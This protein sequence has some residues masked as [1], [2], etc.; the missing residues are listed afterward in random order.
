MKRA[1]RFLSLFL[2]F[3]MTFSLVSTTSFADETLSESVE[4]AVEDSGST[5]DL[6]DESA[7]AEDTDISAEIAADDT[8]EEETEIETETAEDEVTNSL[9]LAGTSSSTIG[10]KP[11]DGTT[12]DQPFAS[13]TGGSSNFRIPA[14]V[15]LNDGTIVA[16]ADARWNNTFDGYGLDTIVARSTDNGQTWNYTF[17]NYLGDNGNVYNTSSTAF[18]DPSLATDGSTVYMLVDLYPG[19]TYIGN[20]SAGTGY[21]SNGHLLLSNNNRSSFDYYVGDYADGYANIYSSD[22]TAVSGYTVDEYFNLY[23]NGTLTSNVFYDD[24]D[25]KV[26]KTSYLYLTK[27]TDGG[28]T[29]S[30]PSMLNSQV[31][32]SSDYFYG[33]GP[34]HGIVTSTGRIIYSCYT[35]AGAD[36]NTSV[37]YSDDGGATWNRSAGMAEQTSEG[38][39]T[40]ADGN[41]YLF[42]RHGGYY[43]SSDNGSTWSFVQSVSGISYTISCELSVLT[44][45]QKIDGKTAI[46]LSAPTSN[47]TNGKIFVGL[48][49]DDGSISWKYTYTVNN[50][51]FQYSCLSETSD[52]KVALLY[53]NGAASIVFDAYDISTVAEGASIGS[54]DNTP[55]TLT[56]SNVTVA[57]TEHVDS[58]TVAQTTVSSI[59]NAYVAFEVTPGEGYDATSATVTVLLSDALNALDASQLTG[60]YIENGTVNK[61]SGTKNSNGTYTF[62][63]PH[64]STVGVMAVNTSSSVDVYSSEESVTL[65]VGQTK[66]LTDSTGNYE[67]SYTGN[68]LD[69]GIA[70]ASVKGSTTEETTEYTVTKSSSISTGSSYIIGNGTYYLT[71]NGS[72]L[73]VTT[74]PENATKWNFTSSGYSGYR[75]YS[76]S[77]YLYRSNNSV[78]ASNYNATTWYYDSSYGFYCYGNYYSY[79]LI[80][81]SNGA[82]YSTSRSTAVAPYTLSSTTTPGEDITN[83]TFTGVSEGTTAVTVGSVKYNITVIAAP[84]EFTGSVSVAGG[85]STTVALTDLN[86]S[87]SLGAGQYVEWSAADSTIADIYQTSDTGASIIGHKKGS[88]TVTATVYNEDDSAAATYTWTVTV[89]S[90]SSSTGDNT[91]TLSANVTVTNGRLYYSI[92][93]TTVK[94]A[95]LVSETTDSYGNTVRTYTISETAYRGSNNAIICY[96]VAPDDGYALTSIAD[97]GTTKGQYY[98]IDTEEISMTYPSSH[99]G[100]KLEDSMTDAEVKAMLSQAV[101]YGC[102]A[103]YWNSRSTSDSFTYSNYCNKLPTVSKEITSVTHNN[104][105][106]DYVEGSTVITVGDTITYTVKLTTYYENVDITYSNAVL[107]DTMSSGSGNAASWTN[108]NVTS[109]LGNGT[110]QT[111]ASKT[112]EYEVTYVVD[113][114]DVDSNIINTIDLNYDYY[115]NYEEGSYNGSDSAEAKVTI[116]SFAPEDIVIDY[117][118][119]V[120]IDY[121]ENHGTYDLA[122]GTANYGD[123]DVKDNVI[124]YTP[125]TVLTEAD[126]VT[127]KNVKDVEYTFTVYPAT[128]VYYEEGFAVESASKGSGKQTTVYAEKETSSNYGYDDAYS[129][130]TTDSNGT[131]AVLSK[132]TSGYV[133]GTFTFTG[134]RVDIFAE[135]TVS[136][137]VMNI[138]VDRVNNGNYSRVKT[139]MVSTNEDGV[140]S[141]S[142][143]YNAP[144]ASYEGTYGTYRVTIA[145]SSAVNLDGF[146]V[147]NTMG[148]ELTEGAA[149]EAYSKHLEDNPN[150]YELRD[151]VLTALNVSAEDSKDYKSLA[152]NVY[153]QIAN[154]AGE[155]NLSSSAVILGDASKGDVTTLL[156]DGPKNEVQL[157]ANQSLT[158]ALTSTALARSVQIGLRSAG[159]TVTYTVNGVEKTLSSTVDMFYELDSAAATN[160]ITVTSGTLLITDLKV[161]DAPADAEIFGKL[162]ETDIV[163]AL[164][165]LGFADDSVTEVTYADATTTV[166]LVDYKGTVLASTE[167]TANGVEGETASFAA[168]DL[169]AAAE[170]VLPSGYAF[171]EEITSD[172]E[173]VYGESG[174]V[175][176][177]IGK[178]ATLKI[179]YK[180]GFKTVGTATL[181][182]VQTSA[183]SKT[184]FTTKEIKAAA[185][186]GYTAI[187]IVGTKVNFGSSKTITATCF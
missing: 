84:T 11:S 136:S 122:S 163:T 41:I 134:D 95:N 111:T 106:A 171:A 62:E 154:T 105:K 2:V 5:E 48:V 19:G 113:E 174:S 169:Q 179:N 147:Y 9:Y 47:R 64:F 36:G 132:T 89:T 40:E 58:M 143:R 114:N 68:G 24:C 34:G 20:V 180:R 100:G 7:V 146:R 133:T 66:T 71:L 184:T 60:F 53:E 26:V 46:I 4:A 167:L 14:M 183:S 166:N 70:T 50:S 168:A 63:V 91:L 158:F 149:F 99:S 178:V 117:G 29:W 119:P 138:F 3:C 126:T 45:S 59:N 6:D 28:A 157:S 87:Y 173:A 75:I 74:S 182:H 18:I 137:G 110:T 112:T 32:T 52:G 186:S 16:A 181:T 77:Y 92:T 121:S 22:G 33:V 15:T 148:S 161:C 85:E 90:T 116:V 67:S 57:F 108:R 8:A 51:T 144:V 139:I 76:G 124:T 172:A 159:G 187:S 98:Q 128:T 120:S 123:V 12:S 151:A 176:V 65:Y 79:Y 142:T 13:G 156:D 17:A 86:S 164:R 107:T 177:L 37:I 118:L 35:Y 31:K 165:Y 69:T 23:V 80:L 93:G 145:T 49:Q 125:N 72:N 101:A 131:S 82:S 25:Y 170:T 38:A 83:I 78:T 44:Y 54:E 94:E 73:G 88:T 153:S 162:T 109:A 129:T 42:T 61:I 150:F 27:S 21:D 104:E 56:E 160:T 103:I 130:D 102:Q 96:M 155:L 1:K 30:A 97:D 115:T 43:V 175:D 127:I 10:T 39:L 152:A 81:S 55:S 185:P 141:L 140:Y 135:N